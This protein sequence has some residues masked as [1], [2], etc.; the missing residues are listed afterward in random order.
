M[1]TL[2]LEIDQTLRQLDRTRAS[3]LESMVRDVI[4][5]VKAGS[6]TPQQDVK[7]QEWLTR[8][9]KLRSSVGTG[10][11]GTSTEAIIEDIHSDRD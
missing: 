8:L 9:D 11:A 10:K 5:R 4:K 3:M 1:S 6:A 7:R 2:A